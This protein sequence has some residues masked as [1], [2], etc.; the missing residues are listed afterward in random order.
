MHTHV[1]VQAN[2]AFSVQMRLSM[3]FDEKVKIRTQK[4]TENAQIY[5]QNAI[6]HRYLETLL[7]NL[8]SAF[9]IIMFKW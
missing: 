5:Y 6:D 2:I 8:T 4:S 9:D 7:I 3:S 1:Y